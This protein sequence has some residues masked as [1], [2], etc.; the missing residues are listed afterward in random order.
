[1][2][3]FFFILLDQ[4][5][6]TMEKLKIERDPAWAVSQTSGSVLV[7][8][9]HRLWDS[10]HLAELSTA[11]VTEGKLPAEHLQLDLNCLAGGDTLDPAAH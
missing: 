7:L 6:F 11:D 5:Y 3:F 2:L 1:M 8:I 4:F 10:V 9:E